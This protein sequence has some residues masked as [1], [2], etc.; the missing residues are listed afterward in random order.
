MEFFDIEPKPPREPKSATWNPEPK[1]FFEEYI[2]PMPI[3]VYV[4]YSPMAISMLKKERNSYRQTEAKYVAEHM[5]SSMVLTRFSGAIQVQF[6]NQTECERFFD[7]TR[8]IGIIIKSRYN[9]LVSDRT[10]F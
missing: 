5:L 10:F 2:T 1:G 9:G 7:A 8:A 4:T 3:W 6:N